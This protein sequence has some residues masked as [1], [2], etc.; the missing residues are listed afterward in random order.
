[1]NLNRHSNANVGRTLHQLVAIGSGGGGGGGGSGTVISVSVTTANGVS[2]SV[3]NATTTPAI[4]ITLG[5]I[6]PTSVAASGTVTGSNLSGTNTGDQSSVSGNAGSATVLANSR[7]IAITGDL[8]WNV[9]FDGSGNVT[10]AGTLANV[11]SNV[12]SFT[13][14]N[15]TVN[16]KGLITAAANG[17]AP[18]V[19]ELTAGILAENVYVGLDTALSADGTFSG[20]TEDGTAGATLAFG[21][22]CYFSVTDSRWELTDADSD[23][24][25]GAVKIG[26]CVL[27]AASDGSATRMLLFGKIR[28]DAKFPALTVGAPVYVSTTAGAVQTAQPS[29]TDDVIRIVG[30]GNTADELYF[31]PSNDYMTHT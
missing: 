5:A 12:G 7:N 27:A 10:A 30:Y 1:M 9:N 26:I 23:S 11:N 15:V 4:T 13:R 3:L 18:G 22:L 25:S 28:A 14:A 8:A 31:H 2:G 20:I 21:D 6:T 29:G 17:S 24:N 19:A 16:A